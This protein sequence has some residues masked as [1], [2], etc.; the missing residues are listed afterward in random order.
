MCGNYAFWM[1]MW[2]FDQ[3]QAEVEARRGMGLDFDPDKN[4]PY[5]RQLQVKIVGTY[6]GLDCI[7]IDGQ[8]CVSWIQHP[9]GGPSKLQY[10]M[11]TY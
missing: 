4:P 7:C 5:A 10:V 3:G 8:P 9:D 11:Q 2:N 1:W 6:S